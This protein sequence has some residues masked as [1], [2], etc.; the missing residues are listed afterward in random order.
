MELVALRGNTSVVYK[1]NS[2][3]ADAVLEQR[4]AV[5]SMSQSER[6]EQHRCEQRGGLMTIG[7]WHLQIFQQNF[8]FPTLSSLCNS[9]TLFSLSLLQFFH[10]LPKISVEDI[11]RF[12]PK[13]S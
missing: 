1:G 7:D 10:L 13:Q 2:S 5:Q 8:Y 6:T 11:S 3:S 4:S 12:Q 9:C